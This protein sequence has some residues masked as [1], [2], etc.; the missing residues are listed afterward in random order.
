LNACGS[1]GWKILVCASSSRPP[2]EIYR[3]ET[4]DA[5]LT[6]SSKTS[7]GQGRTIV[8]SWFYR[9]LWSGSPPPER[10]CNKHVLEPVGMILETIELLER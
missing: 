6:I 4:L 9:I 2:I 5:A 1:D 7:L 10:G 8:Y 3:A